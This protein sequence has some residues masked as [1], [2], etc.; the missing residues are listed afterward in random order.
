MHQEPFAAIAARVPGLLAERGV[1]SLAVAAAR[2]GEIVWE[3]A[4]G[5]ADRER[6]LA[7]TP[8]VM[9]SLAS[10]SKPITATALMLLV[11]RGLVDLDRP[12][13]D[14]LGA[15]KLNGRDFDAREATV[16]RVLTHTAGLPLHYQFFYANEPFPRPPMDETIRRYA[17]LV[18]A[19]DERFQYSNLGYGLL[20]YVIERVSGRPYADFVREEV[21]QPLGMFHAAVDVP[22]QLADYAAARYGRDGVPYAFYTFDHPGGSAV[23]CSAHDLLRFGLFSAGAPLP[24]QRA[25]LSAETLAAMQAGAGNGYGLGWS[26]E[27]DAGG[28]RRVSHSG[29]MGG[30]STLLWLVPEERVAVVALTNSSSRPDV[31]HLGTEVMEDMLAALLPAYA[32]RL[33]ALRANRPEPTSPTPYAPDPALRGVWR[34][35]VATYTGERELTLTFQDDGDIH[36]RL[37]DGL[38]TLVNNATW[39]DGWLTGEFPGDIGTPDASRRRHTLNLD[40]R[41]RDGRLTG[42]LMAVSE[43]PREGGAPG[44]RVGNALN[45]WCALEHAQ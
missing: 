42:A 16:R 43:L 11:E 15:A 21:F 10:I 18:S 30:V 17:N 12:L 41:L 35:R 13:D 5:W 27:A 45:S 36:A 25:I 6:R 26:Y 24:D 31:P 33:P 23:Y 29:G 2:D 14:Y 37:D 3:D 40:L 39:Q 20:D 44:S 9:Y 38:T 34:G 4:W 19:P 7:A 22:P 8:H 28:V 32:E 1:A